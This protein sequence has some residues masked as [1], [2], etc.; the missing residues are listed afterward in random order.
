MCVC[1]CVC[2]CVCLIFWPLFLN[3]LIFVYTGTLVNRRYIFHLWS[4]LR[5]ISTKVKDKILPKET[6]WGDLL[7]QETCWITVWKCACEGGCLNVIYHVHLRFDRDILVLDN[8]PSA[9]PKNTSILSAQTSWHFAVFAI[10]S[11]AQAWEV[12]WK[13]ATSLRT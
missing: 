13:T 4:N 3:Q 2:V 6:V 8:Q 12:S 5:G 11:L 9:T 1:V 10:S 7:T